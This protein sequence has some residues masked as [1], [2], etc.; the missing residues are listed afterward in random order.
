MR[1][2]PTCQTSVSKLSFGL[3][4]V[5]L[6]FMPSPCWWMLFLM[7]VRWCSQFCRTVYNNN[8]GIHWFIYCLQLDT[9][10]L[11]TITNPTDGKSAYELALSIILCRDKACLFRAIK[12]AL[13]ANRQLTVISCP[14]LTA[15]G[16]KPATFQLEITCCH[17]QKI[18][19]HSMSGPESWLAPTLPICQENTTHTDT[20]CCAFK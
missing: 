8:N 5:L 3:I 13:Y 7:V 2:T 4:S 1:E 18:W 15:E 14:R 16:N 9:N 17:L 12:H 10:F 11:M 19:G 6:V 20:H